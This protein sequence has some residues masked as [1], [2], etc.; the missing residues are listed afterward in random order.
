MKN[1]DAYVDHILNDYRNVWCK[2]YTTIDDVPDDIAKRTAQEMKDRFQIEVI[3]GSKYIK[4]V[5][6]SGTS[7]SVHSF[8]CIRNMGKFKQGDILK[9]ASWAAPARNFAR[10][11]ILDCNFSHIR[12]MGA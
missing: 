11:N 10:G 6:K 12:W 2:R 5:H 4:I 9:A 8:I 7:R 3:P 1:L